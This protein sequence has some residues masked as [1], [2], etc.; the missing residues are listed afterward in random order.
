[1]NFKPRIERIFDLE[2]GTARF[3]EQVIEFVK[4]LPKNDVIQG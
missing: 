3:G 1:M 4:T 2:E